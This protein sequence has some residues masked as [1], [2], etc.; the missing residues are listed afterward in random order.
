MFS[1]KHLGRAV[2]LRREALGR[3]QT[4]L[5]RTIGVHKSTM[6][7]YEKGTRGMDTVTIAKISEALDC[8]P[9]EIWDDAFAIFRY[10]FLRELA[11]KMGI[12]I[13]DLV[14]G[15]H[16]RPP[17]E[18]IQASFQTLSN[19]TEQ[20]LTSI[21]AFLRPDRYLEGRL[22]IPTWGVI[23]SS[24]TLAKRKRAIHLQ[25]GERKKPRKR[26]EPKSG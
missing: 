20:L 14:A 1:D 3:D 10:N 24:E 8:E 11:D 4:D 23:V 13:E 25:R 12:P 7:G 22:Q 5:A 21:L 15:I 26:K 16:S 9:I 17:I 2:A 18:Q 6:N 19:H